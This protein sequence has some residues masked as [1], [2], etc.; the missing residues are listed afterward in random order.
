MVGEV[1]LVGRINDYWALGELLLEIN[2]RYLKHHSLPTTISTST[3]TLV[4][5][6][7]L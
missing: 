5:F 7:Q 4:G 6:S 3:T 1:Y 2:V